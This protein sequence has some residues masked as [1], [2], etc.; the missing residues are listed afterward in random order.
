[1]G[2]AGVAQCGAGDAFVWL[3]SALAVAD[4]DAFRRP[5]FVPFADAFPVFR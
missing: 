3:D 4:I 5:F 2:R 1:M